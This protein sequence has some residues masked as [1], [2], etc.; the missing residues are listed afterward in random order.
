VLKT[1]IPELQEYKEKAIT[2]FSKVCGLTDKLIG[3]LQKHN[4]PKFLATAKELKKDMIE[5]VDVIEKLSTFPSE[6]KQTLSEYLASR[7]H[8]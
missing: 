6:D 2:D 5:T 7:R 8:D 1:V 4:T 3:K